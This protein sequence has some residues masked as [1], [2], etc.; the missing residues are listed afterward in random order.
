MI[1]NRLP[2][3]KKHVVGGTVLVNGIDRL[4]KE[5]YWSVSKTSVKKHSRL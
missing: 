5:Y 3:D 1:A 2:E 4:D